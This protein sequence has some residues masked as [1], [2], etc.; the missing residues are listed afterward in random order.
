MP[1][2]QLPTTL[3]GYYYLAIAAAAITLAALLT[4]KSVAVYVIRDL[5]PESVARKLAQGLVAYHRFGASDFDYRYK[6]YL[7]A[8]HHLQK[9]VYSD[10]LAD[11]AAVPLSRIGIGI[12]GENSSDSFGTLMGYSIDLA[13]DVLGDPGADLVA[14]GYEYSD[15]VDERGIVYVVSSHG[16]QVSVLRVYGDATMRGWFGHSVAN[17]GDF[18]GDGTADLLV[19]A[20]FA[21][22]GLGEAYLISGSLLNSSVSDL[23]IDQHPG[24]WRFRHDRFGSD[25]GFEVYFGDDWD[26]DGKHEIVIRGHTEG[27]ESGGVF[28]AFSPLFDGQPRVVDLERSPNVMAVTSVE[29]WH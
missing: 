13:G 26:G 10:S 28:I 22:R 12:P 2:S 15:E 20:R 4:P 18:D 5:L 25:L 24:I 7:S 19:G 3:N 16:D 8:F 14:G 23:R 17:N 9:D 21:N 11:P 6:R 29:D 1:S 27:T